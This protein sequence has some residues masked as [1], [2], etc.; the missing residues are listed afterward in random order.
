MAVLSCA[1]ALTGYAG[2]ANAASMTDN[3]IRIGV[4]ND[5]SGVYSDNCGPGSTAVVKLVA[6]DFGN[7]I[8]GAK[9]EVVVADDQNKPD[10]G[11]ATARK[12]VEQEG[13]DVI[14]GCSASSIALAVHEIMRTNEKPYL[15]AGT[16]TPDLTREACSPYTIQWVHDTY[17][18]PKGTV[19]PLLADGKDSWYFITVDYTFGKQYQ[20]DAT[21]FIEGA[22]GKVVGSVLHPL[23]TT[24]FSSQLLQAQAS[25]AQVIGIA[26]SG[27]D[28]GNLIKQAKEFGI[29]EAGQVLA[30][31]GIQIN[32]IHSIGLDAA[33]GLRFGTAMYWDANDETRAFTKR[34][35]ESFKADRVPN[36]AH[37]GTF[38][39]VKHYL[40]AVQALG[41]DDGKAV[42][43]WMHENPVEDFIHKDIKIRADGQL[44]R[45][46]LSARIKSPDESKYPWDYYEI[47]GELP[48][49]EAWTPVS[50]NKC[51]ALKG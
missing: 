40:K 46:V 11:V 19:T 13:V 21:R 25:G 41:T 5:Q 4:M 37:L 32:M 39:A 14:V 38:T 10:V 27:T 50:E 6:E 23:G 43:E 36:E 49:E 28:F 20:D 17:A 3:V 51:P 22:G 12:W 15:I 9:I 1:T 30:P 7:E 24:D 45:P 18:L 2:A 16:A 33:Q 48:G 34:F 31:L 35:Q 44:M 29:A 42:S 26:N 8:G 47:T